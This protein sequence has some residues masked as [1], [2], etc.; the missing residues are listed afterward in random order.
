MNPM[1]MMKVFMN[2]GGS[3]QQMIMNM[4]GKNSNPMISNLIEMA[5][6]GDNQGIENFARNLFKE[7]GKNFDD[8]FANFM[9]QVK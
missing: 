8:E 2:K 3:P 9:K 4:L 7:K 6:K 5:E 1:E